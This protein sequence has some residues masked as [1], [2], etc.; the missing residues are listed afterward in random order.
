MNVK[1]IIIL[2]AGL[3]GTALTVLGTYL[4][5]DNLIQ[6]KG[7]FFEGL[8]LTGLGIALDIM[9]IIASS[10][11]NTIVMFSDILKKQTEIHNEVISQ[12]QKPSG[13]MGGFLENLMKGGGQGSVVIKDLDDPDS[14]PTEFPLGDG[15]QHISEIMRGGFGKKKEFQDMNIEELEKELAKAV[16][17]D[18]FEKADEIKKEIQSRD[19]SNDDKKS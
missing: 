18:D 14:E 2:L 13:G 11:G 12:A 6:P 19:K 5:I 3:F 7:Y 9:V 16:K 17:K 1:T 8:V 15:I 4:L 10:I